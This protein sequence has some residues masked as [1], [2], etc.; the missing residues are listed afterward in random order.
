M[1]RN[2][3]VQAIQTPN[4]TPQQTLSWGYLLDY[5]FTVGWV[6][7]AGK[8]AILV[9]GRGAGHV[10][11]LD[12]L[13]HLCRAFKIQSLLI[14]CY[15][16]EAKCAEQIARATCRRMAVK[17]VTFGS[18]RYTAPKDVIC[19]NWRL[20]GEPDLE[21]PGV[22]YWVTRTGK[23]ANWWAH[24]RGFWQKPTFEDYG[25]LKETV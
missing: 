7:H 16:V 19:T 23:R 5:R 17:I 6:G 22:T 21:L 20:A 1:N 10:E 12:S 9:L 11:A 25:N 4:P 24:I 13:N 8:K 18:T 3:L 14:C 2:N 15:G